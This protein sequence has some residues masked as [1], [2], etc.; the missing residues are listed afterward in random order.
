MMISF[1]NVC[2]IQLCTSSHDHSS[3]HLYDSL[4]LLQDFYAWEMWNIPLTDFLLFSLLLI[5]T[6]QDIGQNESC[7]P[8]PVKVK[9]DIMLYSGK[10]IN[11][12]KIDSS[13]ITE[14]AVGPAVHFIYSITV[15]EKV[16]RGFDHHNFVNT[17][18]ILKKVWIIT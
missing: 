6:C 5:R 18:T 11:P 3:I 12:N 14:I 2:L 7:L 4:K 10:W 15:F 8:V 17:D 1:H 9:A 13:I 16:V